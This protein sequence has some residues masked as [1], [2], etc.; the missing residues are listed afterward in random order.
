MDLLAIDSETVIPIVQ[1]T[2]SGVTL[3]LQYVSLFL[4]W[5]LNDFSA[6]YA[7]LYLLLALNFVLKWAWN[8]YI[9][10]LFYF[11]YEKQN[12]VLD[13]TARSQTQDSGAFQ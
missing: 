13:S 4:N 7:I 12:I 6:T 3:I 10:G 1:Q 11:E 8:F 2:S 9:G 5:F